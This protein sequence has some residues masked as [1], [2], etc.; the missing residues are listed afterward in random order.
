MRIEVI[1]RGLDVTEAI[2]TYAT[3]KLEHVGKH[4]DG[5]TGIVLTITRHDH[6]HKGSFDV[7]VITSVPKHDAFVCHAKNEDLYAAIDQAEQKATR[8]VTEFKNRLRES[9]R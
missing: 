8:Q 4:F 5:V 1:G 7:E 3:T 2:R 9:G 6:Q